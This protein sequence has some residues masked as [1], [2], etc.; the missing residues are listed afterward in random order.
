[1]IKADDLLSKIASLDE[2]AA[3]VYEQ[4]KR[5][6]DLKNALAAVRERSRLGE[7]L[8]RIKGELDE[9]ARINLKPRSKP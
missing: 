7:L 3:S 2:D 8:A 5:R 9:R 4:A 1:M 6:G